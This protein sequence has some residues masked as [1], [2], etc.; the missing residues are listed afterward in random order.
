MWSLPLTLMTV[1]VEFSSFPG[2]FAVLL[3]S[4][5]VLH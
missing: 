1:E 2:K 3:I 4:L 5:W